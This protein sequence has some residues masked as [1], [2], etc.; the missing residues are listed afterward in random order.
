MFHSEKELEKELWEFLGNP[1]F[2][3]PGKKSRKETEK[4]Q[5]ESQGKNNKKTYNESVVGIKK[6]TGGGPKMV[7]E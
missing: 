1:S 2:Y 5:P 6:M 3:G 4:E 7:E